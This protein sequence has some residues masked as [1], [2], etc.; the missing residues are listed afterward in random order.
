[1]NKEFLISVVIPIYNVGHYLGRTL[2]S[3]RTQS[4]NSWECIMVDDGSTDES[5]CFRPSQIYF[6]SQEFLLREDYSVL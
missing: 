1:M 3:V 5:P 6:H 2:E 4:Y